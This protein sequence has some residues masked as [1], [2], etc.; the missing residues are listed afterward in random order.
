M[1]RFLQDFAF[2]N[3]P[4]CEKTY[5]ILPNKAEHLKCSAMLLLSNNMMEIRLSSL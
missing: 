3:V 4:K 2:P 5:I 1:T